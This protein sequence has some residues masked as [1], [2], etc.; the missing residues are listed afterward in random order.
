MHKKGL[1]NYSWKPGNLIEAKWKDG[2]YYPG[3]IER[4]YDDGYC[5][6]IFD[7]GDISH[8]QRPDEI[9]YRFQEEPTSSDSDSELI[10]IPEKKKDKPE[11]PK[12]RKKT[13]PKKGKIIS[14]KKSSPK[15]KKS[16]KN[17]K[18]GDLADVKWNG[19][20][21]PAVIKNI[22]I[23]GQYLVLFDDGVSYE[24]PAEQVSDSIRLRG[25]G[26]DS[27]HE[28]GLKDSTTI[29]NNNDLK[30][31]V[32]ELTQELKASKKR[33]KTPESSN[34]NNL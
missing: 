34:N 29:E 17:W 19:A 7:D 25:M 28:Q 8:R 18:V 1:S 2:Y 5:I 24:I 31:R 10:I 23:D 15:K 16:E 12:Q 21:Y 20:F 30:K 13:P 33:I 6:I 9:R 11:G 22:A 32:V 4:V 27:D 26:D 14:P 3:S